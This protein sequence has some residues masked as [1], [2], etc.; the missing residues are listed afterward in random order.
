MAKKKKR[1]KK[2]S[3]L[4]LILHKEMNDEAL[5]S[6]SLDLSIQ[7]LICISHLKMQFPD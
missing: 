3:L 2:N 4:N 5:L 6:K 7:Y 1:K